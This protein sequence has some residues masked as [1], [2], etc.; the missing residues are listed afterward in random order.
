M[1]YNCGCE[2]PEDD[3]GRGKVSLGGG[4][5]TESDFVHMA[6]RWNMSVM[7]AKRHTYKLLKKDIEK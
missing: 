2:L 4:S 7:D 6:D 1:C 3:M 5:L